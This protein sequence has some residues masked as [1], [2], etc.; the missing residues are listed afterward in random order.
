[1][2]TMLSATALAVTLAQPAVA[3]TFPTLTTIYVGTGVYDDGGAINAGIATTIHCSNVSGALAQI[4]VVFLNAGGTVQGSPVIFV[5]PHGAQFGTSTHLTVFLDGTAATGQMQ[6]T[7]NVESTE[8]G[9]FCTGVVVNAAIPNLGVTL[10][11]VR[12]NPHPGT[13]E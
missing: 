9:V 5:I 10:N 12:V 7:A 4:R 13:V 1:M 8:S 2:K 6:G 11:L 3:I